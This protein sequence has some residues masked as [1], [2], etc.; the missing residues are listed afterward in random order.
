M[1]STT[2]H[3][4]ISRQQYIHTPMQKGRKDYD[5]LYPISKLIKHPESSKVFIKY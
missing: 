4:Y 1:I 2:L 5:I 3:V